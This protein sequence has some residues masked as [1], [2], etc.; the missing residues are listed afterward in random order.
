MKDPQYITIARSLI[1]VSEIAG[2]KHSGIII[3]WLEKLKAWWRDD[4]TPWCGVFVGHCLKESGY[5]IPKY[6][7]RAKAW[8][9]FGKKVSIPCLGAIVI[10]E[11]KGGGHVGFV[12]GLDHA[13]RLLVLGGNQSNKVNVMAFDRSRVIGYRIPEKI[14]IH[15]LPIL[16][17]NTNLSENE[18]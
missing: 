9:D 8:L 7:M 5:D 14:T 12:I 10:F 16:S 15:P 13:N 1:G 2:A 17:L 11:R 6:Y 18:A 4:E 3:G